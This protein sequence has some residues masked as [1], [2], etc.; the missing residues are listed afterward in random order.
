[1]SIPGHRAVVGA[2]A[3]F[4]ALSAL[5]PAHARITQI[6]IDEV[7]PAFCRDQSCAQYG[8]AGA[9][10]QIA[11]RAFGELDPAD[12]LNALIQDIELGEGRRRQGALRHH[13][14]HHAARSTRRS[15]SGLM[16]HD[17]PN[18]GRP[19]LISTAGARVRRHR[20]RQRLAGRQRRHERRPR[21]HRARHDERRRQSLAAAARGAEMPTAR[22]SPGQVLARII[23][24]VGTAARSR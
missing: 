4:C 23:N 18:R 7:T 9:Y 6:V 3:L 5:A 19:V 21:H 1:M 2:A 24:R 16:W 13:V 10:E 12:P 17:V 14:R 11:G 15:A 8:D 22:R 20:A